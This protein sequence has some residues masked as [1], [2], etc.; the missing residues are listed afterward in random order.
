MHVPLPR[1]VSSKAR[2]WRKA[3]YRTIADGVAQIQASDGSDGGDGPHVLPVLEQLAGQSDGLSTEH[4]SV[5]WFEGSFEVRLRGVRQ[6]INEFGAVGRIPRTPRMIRD[7]GFRP[8]P[9]S[10]GP[11]DARRARRSGSRAAPRGAA[12]TGSLRRSGRSRRCWAGSPARPAPRG[13]GWSCGEAR[14][15]RPWGMPCS[16]DRG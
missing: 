10:R 1:K 14:S 13:K 11:R 2:F 9:S 4:E 15:L 3:S 12:A 6:K 5:A 16:Y 7:D 8:D